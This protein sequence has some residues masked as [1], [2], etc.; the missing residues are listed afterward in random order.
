MGR[1]RAGGRLGALYPTGRPWSWGFEEEGFLPHQ[2]A[3]RHDWWTPERKLLLAVLDDAISLIRR[4]ARGD[5]PPVNHWDRRISPDTPDP[6]AEARAWMAR[7]DIGS[8][9]YTFLRV[10]QELDLDPSW[11]RRQ[12]A[13]P[14]PPGPSRVAHRTVRSGH[15]RRFAGRGRMRTVLWGR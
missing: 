11:V 8:P 15:R 13:Q 6:I 14:A 12:A 9:P 3:R 2:E 4:G 10:C 5:R 1:R 7:G